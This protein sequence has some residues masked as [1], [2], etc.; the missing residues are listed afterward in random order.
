MVSIKTFTKV[1]SCL[2]FSKTAIHN[3]WVLGSIVR[4]LKVPNIYLTLQLSVHG[5]ES[6]LHKLQA[7][8]WETSSDHGEELIITDGFIMVFVE[9]VE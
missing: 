8:N 2:V 9:N 1:N 7:M 3:N 6:F 5:L 4:L